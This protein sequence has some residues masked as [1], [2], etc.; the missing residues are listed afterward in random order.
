MTFDD[1]SHM[2]KSQNHIL[3]FVMAHQ[4]RLHKAKQDLDYSNPTFLKI[5]AG[6]R[7]QS[8]GK[9]LE[10]LINCHYPSRIEL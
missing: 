3:V 10:E 7:I 1:F 9:I 4:K 2:K 8:L 6:N 5:S